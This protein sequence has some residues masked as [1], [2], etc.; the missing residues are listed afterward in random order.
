MTKK[1]KKITEPFQTSKLAG[2]QFGDPDAKVDDLLLICP[3]TIRGVTE[4]LGGSKNIVLGERGAGKSALFR[5]VSE[6]KYKFLSDQ[7]EK[8]RK[9]LIVAIDEDLD[10]ISILN[11]VEGRFVDKA[12]RPHGK[13]L[14]LWEI[15]VLS[16]VI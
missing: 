13:Y 5:L 15:Y 11:V 7:T 8:S 10:Y 9:Q 4:F 6:G 3:Q 12:R 1:D 2:F 16:R 14:F